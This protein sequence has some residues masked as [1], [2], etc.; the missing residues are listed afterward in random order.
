MFII[1]QIIHRENLLK[2][3]VKGRVKEKIN[4][5]CRSKKQFIL[6]IIQGG[7]HAES[8]RLAFNRI[9]CKSM[10]SCRTETREGLVNYHREVGH[11]I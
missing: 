5:T 9:R 8:K 10:M 3:V 4:A 6:H 1:G 2:V 11:W 7:T